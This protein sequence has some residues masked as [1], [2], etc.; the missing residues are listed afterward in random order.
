MFLF[1]FLYGFS[2]YSGEVGA[3]A[4]V[5]IG[6]FVECVDDVLFFFECVCHVVFL[7]KFS[8]VCRV[9]LSKL[10]KFLG[11][12][13]VFSW[14]N[15]LDMNDFSFRMVRA[16]DWDVLVRWWD[17]WGFPRPPREC[18]PKNG[19]MVVDG[20]GD[21]Y[22][23]FL[24]LT[25]GGIG[26]LEWVVS[27]RMASVER[28]RGGLEFLVEVVSG[29]ARDEGMLLLFTSTVLPG[30]RN[31]LLKCGFSMGDDGVYQLIK[32]V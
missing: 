4:C 21:L 11:V 9:S 32:G 14:N 20:E 24:Y 29:L 3:F 7:C 18:L 1:P 10:D 5:S 6:F 8:C 25:D 22:A 19:V 28:R 26:W 23:G 31:G 15:I 2:V 27:D 12:W 17:D 30:F 13:V 16:E